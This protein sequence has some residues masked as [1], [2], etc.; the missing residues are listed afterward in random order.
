M[1]TSKIGMVMLNDEREHVWKKNNPENEE[2]LQKWAKVIKDNLKNIDGS[3]PEV[4]ICS[5]I[6]T[7]VRI[8]Q[9]IGKELATS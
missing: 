9:E 2:V 3:S 7:S 5:K 1:K 8:A 4:I 6:I